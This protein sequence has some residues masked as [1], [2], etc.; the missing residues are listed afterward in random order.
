MVDAIT[1]SLITSTPFIALAVHHE[2]LPIDGNVPYV[3][4]VVDSVNRH[5]MRGNNVNEVR[6]TSLTSSDRAI[7][8]HKSRHITCR[9]I[10]PPGAYVYRKF[11]GSERANGARKAPARR[12]GSS[13]SSRIQHG[14]DSLPRFLPHD[15]NLEGKCT[16]LFRSVTV[17]SP[18]HFVTFLFH[19]QNLHRTVT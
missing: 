15:G 10:V 1:F 18:K 14:L 4:A 13:R 19:R 12:V 17:M 11:N 5:M 9:M 3:S 7:M 16:L 2:A 8:A 6:F